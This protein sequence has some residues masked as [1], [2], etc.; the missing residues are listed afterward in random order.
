M[1]ALPTQDF[2]NKCPRTSQW[3]AET[4]KLYRNVRH[5]AKH[6]DA[7]SKGFMRKVFESG[8]D[9]TD[10]AT[11]RVEQAQLSIGKPYILSDGSEDERERAVWH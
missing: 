9:A 10:L 1:S 3:G 11:E 4:W 7:A 8:H 2:A 5:E 6:H